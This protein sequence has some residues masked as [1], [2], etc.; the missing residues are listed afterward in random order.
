M[1]A[2]TC[3]TC[4]AFTFCFPVRAQPAW[5]GQT[6]QGAGRG[7]HLRAL[8]EHLSWSRAV[9]RQLSVSA[10]GHALYIAVSVAYVFSGT[11]LNLANQRHY[12]TVLE[13]FVYVFPLFGMLFLFVYS[14]ACSMGCLP[15]FPAGPKHDSYIFSFIL[16]FFV[17]KQGLP[18]L[19]CRP[20]KDTIYL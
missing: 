2:K 6:V 13:A 10:R 7:E 11:D 18:R 1:H 19:V 15:F 17:A 20:K 4:R 8:E 9:P 16:S 14:R 12:I 3:L 5:L